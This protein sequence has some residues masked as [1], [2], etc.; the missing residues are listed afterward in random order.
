MTGQVRERRS[1]QWLGQNVSQLLLGG[2][3]GQGYVSFLQVVPQEV[4]ADFDVFG[5]FVAHRVLSHFDARLVVLIDRGRPDRETQRG[6]NL[7]E[8]E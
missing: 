2:D 5:A 6:E 7:L 3:V 4:C 1:G 8:P